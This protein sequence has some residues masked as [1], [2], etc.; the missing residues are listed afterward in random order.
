[1]DF[2]VLGKVSFLK[3]GS[4]LD[5]ME[6]RKYYQKIKER[7]PFWLPVSNEE[8]IKNLKQSK[9]FFPL[10]IAKGALSVSSRRQIYLFEITFYNNL[11]NIWVIWEH[12]LSLSFTY[13][14]HANFLQQTGLNIA[15]K[16][17]ECVSLSLQLMTFNL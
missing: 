9:N 6:K 13:K 5:L 15:R 4:I 2:F 14:S 10:R 12:L 1:M 7:K 8:F 17:L 3:V 11:D 16:L